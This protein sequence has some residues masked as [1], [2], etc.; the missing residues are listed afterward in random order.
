MQFGAVCLAP[1]QQKQLTV[2]ITYT[3][4]RKLIYSV[5]IIDIISYECQSSIIEYYFLSFSNIKTKTFTLNCNE[6]P[7][8]AKMLKETSFMMFK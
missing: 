8:C 7:V 6:H 5:G 1:M 2:T 3:I 4:K